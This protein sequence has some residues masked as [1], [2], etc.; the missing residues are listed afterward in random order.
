MADAPDLSKRIVHRVDGMD[1]VAVQRDVRYREDGDAPLL[2][3]VYA[4]PELP[5]GARLPALLFIH[6][7]P[8]PAEMPSPRR[9]GIFESYGALAAASG[10]VGITFNHR[11]HAPEDYA[12]AE[13]DVRAAVAH[14]R[15][16]ADELRVDSERIGLWAFSG[17][18]P[19]V[20]WALRERPAYVRCLLAFY[21]LL[22]LRHL[23]P[24]GAG[25]AVLE[26]VRA[27]SPAAQLAAGGADLPVFVARAGRDGAWI[28]QSID[29]F[30]REAL[31]ANVQLDLV[32]HAQGQHAF[33]AKDDDERSRE[34]IARA[35]AFARAWLAR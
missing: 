3:D 8:I 16:H 32:N 14:V 29:S 25:A 34:I 20:S 4:P 22:D 31:A 21:A 24:P 9:W 19:L 27:L 7:G 26:Q 6:G 30:V 13:G 35:I 15:A 10:L 2:M 1:R 11:L 17:G 18:G 28:N 12:R 33:D 23:T 5:P